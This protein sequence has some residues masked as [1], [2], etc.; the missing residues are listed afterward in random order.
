[1]SRSYNASNA[2]SPSCVDALLYIS[3]IRGMFMLTGQSGTQYKQFVHK[4]PMFARATSLAFCRVCSSVFVKIVGAENNSA[5]SSTC[6]SVDMPLTTICTPGK[7]RSHFKAQDA[8]LHVG[9]AA[10]KISSASAGSC[11]SYPPRTGSITKIGIFR[12][13][14]NAYSSFARP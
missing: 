13:I 12:S 9:C 10:F 4:T 11:A 7:L 8:A 2:H 3:T 1:M 6:S 5:F 14:K